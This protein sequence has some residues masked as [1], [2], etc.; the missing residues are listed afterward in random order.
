MPQ[1]SEE[2]RVT[3]GACGE[4]LRDKAGVGTDLGRTERAGRPRALC[5]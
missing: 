5:L 2:G 4:R 1:G 3:G